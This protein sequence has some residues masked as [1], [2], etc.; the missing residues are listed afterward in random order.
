M[1]KIT[2]TLICLIF[3]I[4][5]LY[6]QTWEQ[7][8]YYYQQATVASWRIHSS[9]DN[10]LIAGM[11]MFEGKISY[12][13]DGGTT[14]QE[15]FSAKSMKIA[16]F[17]PDYTIYLATEKH[18]TGSVYNSDTLFKSSNGINWTA[19]GKQAGT[20]AGLTP[21]CY[22]IAP[23]NTLLFPYQFET[24]SPYNNL[25]KST[26]NG[27][28]W[29]V[30]AGT[31]GNT[32]LGSFYGTSID[33][34]NNADTIVIGT[35]NSGVRYSHNGGLTFSTATGGN[36]GATTV[37]QMVHASNGDFYGA[38]LGLIYK[39]TDGGVSFTNL[40]PNPCMTMNISEL[41][42]APNGKFYFYGVYG[43][44]ES[45]DCIAWTKISDNLPDNNAIRDIDVSNN[46][47]Y[48]VTDT[49][50][51]RLN[52]QNGSGISEISDE[53]SVSIYPNPCKESTTLLL[54]N[55]RLTDASL[56]IYS[57]LGEKVREIQNIYGN[58]III[59]RDNLNSGMYFY[60][61]EQSG[62][63]L[64]TGNFLIE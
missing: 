31:M 6:S 8:P 17:G 37:G 35:Y 21:Q 7:L 38:G 11:G 44:F 50:L 60:K 2:Y 10:K 34:S 42:Y 39:S 56:T 41:L 58:K 40:S 23:N 3:S 55:D 13:A 28:T 5:M 20:G 25:C 45:T 59:N 15:V 61:L 22:V 48:A 46:Y 27:S 52:I 9:I 47:L 26:D 19:I 53:L 29:S 33:C 1:K 64:K 43:I 51:Y 54:N 14:W 49:N 16:E 12:S 57:V 24:S 62:I 36:W 30:L 63:N 18:L 4:S 32:S